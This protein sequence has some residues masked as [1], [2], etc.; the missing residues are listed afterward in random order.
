MIR[1][2]TDLM[3]PRECLVCG[4]QLGARE[5]H[6]CIWCAEDLPFTYNWNRMHNPMA[7]EFNA[8][9]ESRRS[10]GDSMQY[11]YAAALLFYH[12]GNPYKKIPQALKYRYNLSAGRY[13]SAILGRNMALAAHFSSIDLVIPVPLHWSRKWRRGYNQAEVIARELA[14]ALDARLGKG[15]LVRRRR[16][17]TQTRLDAEARLSNVSGVFQVRRTVP[18]SHLLLVD[19]TFTTGAT[20]A[21]CYQ[22]VRAA[23]GPEVRISV[24]T[25]SVVSS[26]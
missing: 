18:S 24:A 6:L 11:A 25:L 8:L 10:D 1:E 4:Q 7:D 5:D 16:T 26:Q 14:G 15:I 17:R 9:L 21:A 19:D 12:R 3:M 22:A 20:L 13:F 2:L 23:F